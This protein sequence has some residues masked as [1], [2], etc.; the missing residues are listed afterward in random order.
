MAANSPRPVYDAERISAV[1]FRY[2]SL[3]GAEQDTNRLLELNAD[4]ARDLS[5]AD[6]CSIWLLDERKKEL[7]TKVAHGTREIRVPEG[8]GLVGACVTSNQTVMSNDV[9][10]DKRFFQK[11]DDTSG[12]LTH[13]VLALP[14]HGHSGKVIGV[15]Q[16]LNKPAGFTQSDV[17]MLGLAASYAASTLETQRLRH[18][19][20]ATRVLYRELEIARDVQQKLL[21]QKFP[22]VPGLEYAGFCRPARAVGGDYYDFCP[23][24]DGRFALTLGDVS[25]KGIAAALM[26]AGI[27]SSLRTQMLMGVPSLAAQ[28]SQF[29]SAIYISSPPDK[30]STLFVGIID[31]SRRELSYVNAGQVMPML[32]RRGKVLRLKESGVPIGLLP[33]WQYE[34]ASVAIEAGDLLVCFSDGIS[35]AENARGEFW[36]EKGAS[37]VVSRCTGMEVIT[38]LFQGCDEFAAGYEQSDDITVIAVQVK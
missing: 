16:V 7:W 27:H 28:L 37:Q 5:G 38:N 19:A 30:Y 17:E 3:I 10:S 9:S 34:Q 24:E 21:P 20:E 15:L 23:L 36:E 1:I 33:S 29:N 4:M 8:S 31:P 13:S 32:V 14:L 35:E 25:G 22:S 6:R 12:Y 2:A 18:E 11:V 26:M